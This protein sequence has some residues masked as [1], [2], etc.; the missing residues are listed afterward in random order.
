MSANSAIDAGTV[1]WAGDNPGIYLKESSDGDW[2]KLALFFR[3]TISPA[4]PGVA[5][6]VLDSPD[7]ADG[8]AAG[9]VCI[10]DN[11]PLLEYL[12]DGFISRFPT[13]RNRPGLA[14]MTRLKLESSETLA[15]FDSHEE[16]VRADNLALSMKWT[17]LGAPFAVAVEPPQSATGDHRMYSAFRE[18]SG[19]SISIDG[20]P[21]AGAVV[22]RPFF[23]I[24]MSSAFLAF[25]EI[26]ITP[27][28]SEVK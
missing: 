17:G 1:D 15:G 27:A 19:A 10:T 9:N 18:A 3:V 8:I 28:K 6:V 21:L 16:I 23:G 5:M 4:G 13:F 24:S 14:A 22:K 20:K 25:A 2:K 11:M 7:R 26:W 12:A